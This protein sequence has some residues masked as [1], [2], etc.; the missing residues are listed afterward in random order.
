MIPLMS[1]GPASL[2]LLAGNQDSRCSTV[3][4]P[5]TC[6]QQLLTPKLAP[7]HNGAAITREER[8]KHM[9]KIWERGKKTTF[10][11]YPESPLL[12]SQ[13]FSLGKYSLKG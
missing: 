7:Q 10:F 5:V 11:V 8:P 1:R 13:P 6:L 4:A 12:K 2:Q 9:P 3:P